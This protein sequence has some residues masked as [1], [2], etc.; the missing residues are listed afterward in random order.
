MKI[1]VFVTLML[2]SL[3][4]SLVHAQSGYGKPVPPYGGDNDVNSAD[5]LWR[6]LA[7][8]QLAGTKVIH[9]TPYPGVYPHGA[10]LE[11]L[12]AEVNVSGHRGP[13]IITRNYGGNSASKNNVATYPERYLQ[14]ITVMFKRERGYD[15]DNKDWFWV[16]YTPNGEIFKDARGRALAGRVAKDSKTEGCIACHKTAPGAD[17]VF[18]HDR[19]ARLR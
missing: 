15:P 2:L 17:Y 1:A 3:T 7:R 5:S 13:V 10:V 16:K 19:Y 8:E 4:T 6:A 14:S 9:S 18:N 11:M 12:D